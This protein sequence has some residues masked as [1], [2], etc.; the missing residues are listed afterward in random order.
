MRAPPFWD[1]RTAS[2]PARLLRPVAALYGAAAAW[3]LRRPGERAPLP[4]I[5]V[6]NFTVGGAGKTP[7]ALTL[8][9]MLVERGEEPAFLSR[10]YGGRLAGPVRVDP[11]AHGPAEVGDEPLLL[12]RAA[13]TIVS[14]DRRAGA[15][16]CAKAGASVVVMDDGLQNP[17]LCKDRAVAV[18]DGTAGIGNGFCLPAG[19][20]RAP[21]AAQWPLVDALVLVGAGPAGE[22]VAAEAARRGKAV[23][24]ARLDPDPGAA[25]RICGRRVLAFAGI[26]RPEKFF[27]TVERCGAELVERRP[28]PDHHAYAAGE[29]NSL[30][31]DAE[32]TGLLP[33]TTEK[34]W[35]RIAALDAALARRISA[36]PVTLAFEDEAPVRALLAAA[37]D[38]NANRA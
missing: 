1:K 22:A 12:A 27:E 15:R 8:A 17:S 34:D 25:E 5:C 21:L 31:E 16:A 14:R 36:L 19:P 10:G 32:R 30:A 2:L 7:A 6:G 11:A 35:V 9:R 33:V 26:G 28:F 37:L 23:F 29:L 38:R 3:R 13:P 24:R 20:L 18:V 4:V